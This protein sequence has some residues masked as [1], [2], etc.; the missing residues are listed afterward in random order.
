LL[1]SILLAWFILAVP[2]VS[3]HLSIRPHADQL[4]EAKILK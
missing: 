2:L 4:L 3:T 1:G